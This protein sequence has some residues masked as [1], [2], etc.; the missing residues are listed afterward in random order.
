M[1]VNGSNNREAENLMKNRATKRQVGR[2]GSRAN[3]VTLKSCNFSLKSIQLHMSGSSPICPLQSYYRVCIK[4]RLCIVGIRLL[5][6]NGFEFI[7]QS[8]RSDR[9][10]VFS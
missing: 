6:N 5:L 2:G 4:N 1:R 9:T 8:D 3:C 10:Y 7:Y